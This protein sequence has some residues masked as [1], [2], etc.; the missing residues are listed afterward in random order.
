MVRVSPGRMSVPVAQDRRIV[1]AAIRLW[2]DHKRG[3]DYFD[4]R[5]SLTRLPT[6]ICS[7]SA[8]F[9]DVSNGAHQC[10]LICLDISKRRVLAERVTAGRNREQQS[11]ALLRPL[12]SI[13]FLGCRWK[14]DLQ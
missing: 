14:A 2:S 10:E 1:P 5:L 12:S 11:D 6:S 3:K 4:L 8:L 7:F 9:C 13:R